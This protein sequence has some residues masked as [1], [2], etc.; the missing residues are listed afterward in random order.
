MSLKNLHLPATMD[1]ST[2]DMAAD[3]YAPALPIDTLEPAQNDQNL[4]LPH[5]T[6]QLSEIKDQSEIEPVPD[7]VELLFEDV[8]KLPIITS[9]HQELWLGIQLKAA[10]RWRSFSKDNLHDIDHETACLSICTA[11]IEK[12]QEKLSVVILIFQV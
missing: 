7:V 6:P 10:Q 3:I 9:P 12:Y 5:V 2:A 8:A 4:D 11:F 1:T